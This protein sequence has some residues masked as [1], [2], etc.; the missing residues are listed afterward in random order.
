MNQAAMALL[1]EH[2]FATFGQAPQGDNTIREVFAVSWNRQNELLV[3]SIEATAFLYRM[4]RSL[5]GTLKAVGDGSWTVDDFV[6][7]LHAQ[8][9]G[10]AGTLA[11]PHGLYLVDVSYDR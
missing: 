4:V 8:D 1:G 10:R 5:V 3:F 11:P 2:D 9:R 7:A 6:S